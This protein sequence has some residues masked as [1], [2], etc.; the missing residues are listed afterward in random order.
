MIMV[1]IAMQQQKVRIACVFG[2][3]QL[4]IVRPQKTFRKQTNLDVFLVQVVKI[5]VVERVLD[6]DAILRVV[7]QKEFEQFQAVVVNVVRNAVGV[8]RLVPGWKGGVPVLQLR[9]TGP[10]LLG[11][12]TKLTEDFV[13]LI[14]FRVAR[15]EGTLVDHFRKD[16]SDGPNIH[17]R[18]VGLRS[19]ENFGRA[20]PE[21]DHFVRQGANGRAKGA[22]QTKVSNLENTV[23][24][25]QQILGFE[26][27]VHDATGVAKR[28]T[29]ADLKEIR[30]DERRR[31]QSGARF[32]VLFQIFV[33][34]FK[35]EIE[36]S[37]FL[38]TVF[39][40]DNVAVGQFS[41]QTDFAERRGGDSFVLYFQSNALES[42]N[43]IGLAVARFVNYSVRSFSQIGSRLFNLLVSVFVSKES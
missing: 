42:N 8:R 25:D 32:H 20:V 11:G 19:H 15:E 7:R 1:C 3:F 43:F 36:A 33:E 34:E 30:L 5:S 14:N 27:A 26:I 41:Q 29:A 9:D 39:Q 31:E 22:G 2:S 37:I 24:R 21:R 12:R 38:H 16:G 23:A 17:G 18:R 4:T 13:E 10:D 6:R 40:V 35:D 28:E